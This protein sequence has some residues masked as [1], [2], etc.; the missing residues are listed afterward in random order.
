VTR[1][2]LPFAGLILGLFG[3]AILADTLLLGKVRADPL[4]DGCACS[5]PSGNTKKC[6]DLK[7]WTE[8]GSST[9]S[10]CKAYGYGGVVALKDCPIVFVTNDG[11][12][13][14]GCQNAAPKKVN[15]GTETI[16]CFRHT[17]C[18]FNTDTNTCE[19]DD[20]HQGLAENSDRR[21]EEDCAPGSA[22]PP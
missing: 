9:E 19:V 7:K 2:L 11:N 8:C 3:L 20:L 18:K 14:D 12:V 10:E 17:Y 5:T 15:C 6:G 4:P 22:C 16:V 1:K 13:P 21:K